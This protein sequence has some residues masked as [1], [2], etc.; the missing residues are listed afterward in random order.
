LIGSGSVTFGFAAMLR[1]LGT[2]SEL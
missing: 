2:L 1:R